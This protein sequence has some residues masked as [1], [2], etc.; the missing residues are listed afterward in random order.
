MIKLTAQYMGQDLTIEFT[1]SAV[2]NI[3]ETWAA[4]VDDYHDL[5]TDQISVEALIDAC[6]DGADADSV[7]GW[8]DYVDCLVAAVARK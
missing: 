5:R 1:E 8:T 7:Q 3:N 6:T 2:E 4:W